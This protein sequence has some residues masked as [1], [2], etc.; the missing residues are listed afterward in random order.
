[1]EPWPDGNGWAIHSA[2]PDATKCSHARRVALVKPSADNALVYLAAARF[3][4]GDAK[5]SHHL[6]TVLDR[7]SG[8]VSPT[9]CSI[10]RRMSEKLIHLPSGAAL[11]TLT[12][13]S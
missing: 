3:T 12:S 10:I 7:Y 4:K 13:A 8:R 2:L 5:L 9:S 11:N 1:M 6:T